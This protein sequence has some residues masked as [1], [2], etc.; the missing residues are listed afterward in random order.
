MTD[1]TLIE[2]AEQ[3]TALAPGQWVIALDGHSYCLVDTHVGAPQRM[4]MSSNG[5]MFTA[6]DG[7][8]YP[9][10][11]ADLD[12]PDDACAHGRGTNEMGHCKRCGRVVGE[13]RRMFFD[14]QGIAAMKAA[15]AANE[16]A[17]GA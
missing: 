9:L 14:A 5:S 7:I 12:E 1:S 6:V 8:P 13:A 16:R 15:A 3:T 2:N 11:L 4:W 17:G 10:R